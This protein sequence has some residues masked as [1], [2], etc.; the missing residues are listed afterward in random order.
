MKPEQNTKDAL[1]HVEEYV[2]MARRET[3]T[4]H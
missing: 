4:E 2:G 1:T 3:V